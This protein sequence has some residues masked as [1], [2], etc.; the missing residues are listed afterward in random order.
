M[1][2]VLTFHIALLLLL[3]C[4]TIHRIFSGRCSGYRTLW[5]TLK[6][7][8]GLRVGKENVRQL[9]HIVNP[10]GV[11]R[12]LHHRL[13]R[14]TYLSAGPNYCWHVDGYDKLKKFGIAINGCID[15]FSRRVIWLRCSSTNNDPAVIGCYYLDAV[16]Q[17][18]MCPRRL[19]S[20]RGSE[21]I[22]VATIQCC[23]TGDS[24]AHRFGSS[25]TN[26]RIESFWSVLRQLRMQWWIDLFED[27]VAC[28]L[29]DISNESHLEIVRF[30]FMNIIQSDIQVFANNW[31]THR[32][33][34]SSTGVASG[35][36]D[37]L[38]FLPQPPYTDCALV[39]RPDDVNQ[40][41]HFVSRPQTCVNAD[42]EDYLIYLMG[43]YNAAMP[44]SW[45]G[46][47]DLFIKLASSVS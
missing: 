12:R 19:R 4:L 3:H 42:Y 1:Q 39:V 13:Q 21:N 22:T 35:V 25:C 20:D 9:M 37:E 33:R 34:P 40:F 8:Y 31:N 23:I 47:T 27:L 6:I 44:D 36:P 28:D 14:R 29:L 30:C 17:L 18:M 46:A 5:K 38:F 26:Q 45:Q 24:D 41:R 32:I 43:I 16:Q 10:N 2:F 7:Q 11:R 15:G